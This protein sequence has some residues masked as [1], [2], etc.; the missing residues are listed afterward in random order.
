MR[1]RLII[2]GVL[3]VLALMAFGAEVLASLRADHYRFVS[4]GEVW[5]AADTGSLN[6]AQAF[7]QRYLFP[8]I[9]DPVIVSILRTP[10]WLLPLILSGL[11][12]A[13]HYRHLRVKRRMFR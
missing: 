10:A 13:L 7:I 11:F 6:G 12:F 9:W 2:A 4:L 8:A 3:L 1:I 5:F